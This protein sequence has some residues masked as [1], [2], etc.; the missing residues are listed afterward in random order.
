MVATSPMIHATPSSCAGEL[1]GA[2]SRRARAVMPVVLLD[3][4]GDSGRTARGEDVSA[5]R[6]LPRRAYLQDCSAKRV[7]AEHDE[8]EASVCKRV[9]AVLCFDHNY[10]AAAAGGI[11]GVRYG[12]VRRWRVRRGQQD[13]VA[14][15]NRRV[16]E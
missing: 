15:L 16:R 6:R 14:I 13:R 12:A 9:I 3:E 11:I 4:L 8:M 10:C 1:L 5:P 7:I 2:G